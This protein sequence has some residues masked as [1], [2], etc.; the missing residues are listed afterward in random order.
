MV[1]LAETPLMVV[2]VPLGEKLLKVFMAV[3][4]CVS[5]VQL[6]VTL[7]ALPYSSIKIGVDGLIDQGFLRVLILMETALL[8]VLL[9]ANIVPV[10]AYTSVFPLV[11]VL[12]H[13]GAKSMF[14]LRKRLR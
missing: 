8:T 9:D 12:L 1:R 4:V 11:T 5:V 14:C 3:F 7:V 10:V 6:W 2:K 13:V